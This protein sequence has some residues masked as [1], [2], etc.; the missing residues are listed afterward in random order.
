M[1]ID[2]VDGIS[3]AQVAEIVNHLSV[4]GEEVLRRLLALFFER[5]ALLV[6]INPLVRTVAGA[7]V[8]ADAKIELDD[9]GESADGTAHEQRAA[10]A[11][12][13]MI[14]LGGNVAILANGAGLTMATMDA[15][16]LAG[17]QPAKLLRDRRRCVHKGNACT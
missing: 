12:L 7:L 14:E 9:V 8:A 15:V 1:S 16:S 5:R 3:S 11:G 2:P 10:A 17:G 6:E 13:R 4:D